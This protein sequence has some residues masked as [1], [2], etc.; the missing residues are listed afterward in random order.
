S[1]MDAPLLCWVM[2]RACR[3]RRHGWCG[4]RR[5]HARRITQHSS[6]ASIAELDQTGDALGREVERSE[7][8][9]VGGYHHVGWTQRVRRLPEQEVD[10]QARDTERGSVSLR[11]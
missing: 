5:R 2:R 4:C 9:G 11:I 6:G 7:L 10:Q 1:A 3:L 8:R